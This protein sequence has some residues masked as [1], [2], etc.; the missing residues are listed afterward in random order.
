RAGRIEPILPERHRDARHLYQSIRI[1]SDH[2]LLLMRKP[3][4]GEGNLRLLFHFDSRDGRLTKLENA[5][6]ASAQGL[7]VSKSSR[8][9]AWPGADGRQNVARLAADG[10]LEPGSHRAFAPPL[11]SCLW[12]DSRHLA[13]IE[14]VPRAQAVPGHNRVVMCGLKA[15]A[16]ECRHLNP[17]ALYAGGQVS[18]WE[19][20][21][22][23]AGVL[24]YSKA[25]QRR[26]PFRFSTDRRTLVPVERVPAGP[27]DVMGYDGRI[28]RLGLHHRAFLN[29]AQR[30]PEAVYGFVNIGERTFGIVTGV[31]YAPTPAEL[32]DGKWHPRFHGSYAPVQGLAARDFWIR[33]DGGKY[34]SVTLHGSGDRDQAVLYFTGAEAFRPTAY[35]PYTHALEHAGYDAFW[36]RYVGPAPALNNDPGHIDRENAREAGR[37]ILKF[38]RRAGYKRVIAWGISGGNH[39]TEAYYEGGDRPSGVIDYLNNIASAQKKTGA[40]RATARAQGFG[41]FAVRAKFDVPELEP[42]EVVL[43]NAHADNP[44][45]DVFY[46]MMRKID[47]FM[48]ETPPLPQPS[49]APGRAWIEAEGEGGSGDGY[50][51]GSPGFELEGH[52]L[53]ACPGARN[54]EPVLNGS[55]SPR[56]QPSLRPAGAPLLRLR[57]GPNLAAAVEY[58]G[59]ASAVAA[60]ASALARAT[61]F[62]LRES[63]EAERCT[64]QV[65]L[66]EERSQDWRQRPWRLRSDG[67]VVRPALERL[68]GQICPV[69]EA[70]AACAP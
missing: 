5:G 32:I 52:I 29:V 21:A 58:A 14:Q 50:F 33:S 61:G 44:P 25:A 27:E 63:P 2:E 64:I 13:G 45:L 18:F 55:W 43:P 6:V 48:R 57:S 69:L 12:A 53:D 68:A 42:V 1:L 34:Y 16:P 30:A 10:S 65:T 28:F 20:S 41:F 31:N 40:L 15:S 37:A 67:L 23:G 51:L 24:M 26:I 35:Y 59:P 4:G 46:R 7:C 36:V 62:Q 22:S 70:V 3:G 38:A 56:T 49:P 9:I 11:E 66:R 54:F 39:V 47:A 19:S 8:Q 60:Q 17:P